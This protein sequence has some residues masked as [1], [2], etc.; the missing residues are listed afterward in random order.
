MIINV[1]NY[2]YQAYLTKNNDENQKWLLL[3]GFMGSHCDFNHII[4]H[5][6]GQV[7]TLDLLGFG[8]HTTSV[9]V[10]RF[11]MAHQIQDLATIL[12]QLHWKNINLLGYSMGGRLALGFT[13]VHSELVQRLYL[14]STTAGLKTAQE[15]HERCVSDYKKA[16]KIQ[17]HFEKFVTD[18]EQMPLFATQQHVSPEQKKF[19]HQQRMN[20]NP[21]NVANS[22]RY[23]GSGVQ[24]NYWP[25]LKSLHTPTQ[26]IVGERDIKFNLIAEEMTNLLPNAKI[27][28]VPNAGH[29]TH[30]E[31]PAA[32]I[33]VLD[34]SN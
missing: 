8:G 2:P 24:P 27:S 33:E 32:L 23:M 10:T 11:E 14:E 1:N 12:N 21:I 18:W 26:V 9:E 28:I 34:V 5:L 31:Q 22:L 19:M 30:F 13:T 25:C 16:E 20:Q 7:L 4:D 3:H 6:P 15:R 17:Q 29:N